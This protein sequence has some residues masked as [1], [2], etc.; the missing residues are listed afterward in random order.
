[1]AD[2][3]QGFPNGTPRFLAELAEHNERSWF[4]S[5]RPD[6]E[7][8]YVDAGRAFVAALGPRLQALWPAI[9]YD[10][11]VNG[12]LF[13]INRDIRFT[14]DKSPYKT[15]LD[16]WFW[17]GEHRG[18]DSPGVFFRLTSD[19]VLLGCGMHQLGKDHLARFRES[20]LDDG[21]G[22]ELTTI[23]ED[24][25]ETGEYEIG[26]PTRKRLPPGFDPGHP[27]AELLRHDGL[28]ATWES[29]ITPTIHTS[30]FVDAC[31][32]HVETMIPVVLWL[33]EYVV[34]V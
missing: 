12:S 20:I 26:G 23:L 10:P 17:S 14:H 33:A 2:E 11:R 9:Q 28:V 4:E 7:A 13:R 22:S 3:F 15:H 1:V 25:R 16:C 27:R 30:D 32:D 29:P 24:I 31:V 34:Q 6:Y 8:Y 19:T 5:H 21:A 18:W